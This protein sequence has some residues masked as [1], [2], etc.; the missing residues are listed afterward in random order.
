M[1]DFERD[2][3]AVPQEIE[4][5][6]LVD[7]LKLPDLEDV[8]YKDIRQGYLA[9]E[10]SGSEVRLR[11]KGGVYT[12]AKKMGKGLVRAEIE[13]PI[14]EELFEALW[15]GTEGRVVEKRRYTI[16]HNGRI[17]EL[18]MFK[19]PLHV[20]LAEVEFPSVQEANAFEAPDWFV[21]D[22]TSDRTFKNQ[23][24]ALQA[25]AEANGPEGDPYR[26]LVEL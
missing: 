20:V 1:T 11:D 8:P 17:I 21:A 12:I 19:S 5:K 22:V 9:I 13:M 14:T 24:L 2:F 6:F 10:P 18:D 7:Q 25:L 4:R 16:P 15:P 3:G 23:N 26:M